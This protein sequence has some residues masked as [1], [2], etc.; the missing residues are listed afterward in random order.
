MIETM[1]KGSVSQLK[2]DSNK[3]SPRSG[4]G[5]SFSSSSSS[6]SISFSFMHQRF[7]TILFCFVLFFIIVFFFFLSSNHHPTFDL[8]KMDEKRMLTCMSLLF[9]EHTQEAVSVQ[10]LHSSSTVQPRLANQSL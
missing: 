7:T 6:S 10:Y 9:Q 4:K 1:M 5:F 3:A 8:K 2:C